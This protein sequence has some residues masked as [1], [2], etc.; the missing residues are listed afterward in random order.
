MHI[1]ETK[2]HDTL[3]CYAAECVWNPETKKNDKPSK[4]VG[5]LDAEN[6]F[7]PNKF[8]SEVLMRYNSDPCS[9]SEYEQKIIGS[10]KAKYGEDLQ[11][12]EFTTRDNGEISKVIKTASIIHHGPQLVFESITSRY[13]LRSLLKKAFGE[14]LAQDILS[15]A[16]YITSEGSALSNNDSWL[17]YFENPRGYGFSS[18]GVT[19]LLDHIDYD[20]IMTFYKQ[21]LKH[22]S[23][24]DKILYDLTSISYHGTGINMTDW[25]Q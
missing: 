1:T 13:K 7:L 18:Q 20:G 3:Y 22:S 19:K 21:W 16:W 17:D 8:L 14:D 11:P 15:L 4:A 24:S 2:I 5:K 25:G 10:V 23:G 9:I 6:R 12:R